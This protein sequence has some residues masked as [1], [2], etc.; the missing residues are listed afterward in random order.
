MPVGDKTLMDGTTLCQQCNTRFKITET[1][2]QV[3]NGM[4]RCGLCL[5]IFD[6]RTNFVADTP[7]PQLELP[8]LNEPATPVQAVEFGEPVEPDSLQPAFPSPAPDVQPVIPDATE[9]TPP[10]EAVELV[11]NRIATHEPPEE[12]ESTQ[13][14]LP[15]PD[16]LAAAPAE[17]GLP[18]E[19]GNPEEPEAVAK[20]Y[21]PVIPEASTPS[22]LPFKP[23][24]VPRTLAEQVAVIHDEEIGD[25]GGTLQP[26]R[27]KWPWAIASML[28]LMTLLA[29]S[30]YF[31]RIEIAAHLP[32]VK[33]LLIDACMM[34]DCSV[35][36]P[37]NTDLMSIESSEL[38]A[39]PARESLITLNAL[40]RNRASYTQ[41][42]P[43]LEL[44]LNNMD[45]KP[46]ARRIF[47]PADY[48]S[49]PKNESD[50]LQAGHELAIKLHLDVT[51]LKP[52]GYRLVLFYP[53]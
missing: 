36:L 2:M 11:D 48:L 18:P 20:P 7:S 31:F 39:D 30:A 6:A 35:P 4:V 21:A 13:P 32:G 34:L 27:R 52:T 44:T 28:L 43:N 40:L 17:A 22:P 37:Q 38:E 50:G 3:H 8:I 45:D 19:S 14:E 12:N 5:Q 15:E 24:I 33:P 47:R 25:G 51:D 9:P 10:E 26:K 46:M 53:L 23:A 49:P 29:Q 41:A 1:Q 16:Q 42:F